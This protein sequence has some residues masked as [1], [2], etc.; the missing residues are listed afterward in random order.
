[1]SGPGPLTVPPQ[2]AVPSPSS[3]PWVFP[4]DVSSV[5][6]ALTFVHGQHFAFFWKETEGPFRMFANWFPSEIRFLGG[7]KFAT[8]EHA[9]MYSKAEVFDDSTSAALILAAPTPKEAKDLGRQVAGFDQ[10]K[11]DSV[12][13]AVM[14]RILF[15]KFAQNPNLLAVLLNTGDARPTEVSPYDGVWGAKISL[16]DAL[17][18]PPHLWTGEDMLGVCLEK[19]RKLHRDRLTDPSAF[20]PDIGPCASTP[21]LDE[22]IRYVRVK[23][24]RSPSAVPN[25]PAPAS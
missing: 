13:G 10:S 3:P 19:V 14:C 16:E 1:M 24:P 9:L 23:R 18:S 11:W 4:T 17:R 7:V 15:A 20:D 21:R 22:V 25:L 8:A 2:P 12:K 5:V 6:A